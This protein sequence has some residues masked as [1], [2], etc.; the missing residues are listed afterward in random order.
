MVVRQ[1]LGDLG[2]S[3]LSLVICARSLGR[4]VSTGPQPR[5]T[6]VAVGAKEFRGG[7]RGGLGGPK[8]K[9]RPRPAFALTLDF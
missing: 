5:T 4:G 2:P 9:R 1:K 6:D 7:V 3:T 8:W